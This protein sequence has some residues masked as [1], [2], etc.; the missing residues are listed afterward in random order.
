MSHGIISWDPPAVPNGP[1]SDMSYNVTV[2]LP[3]GWQNFSVNHPQTEVKVSVECKEDI[4]LVNVGVFAVNIENNISI[5]G[6]KSTK[7]AKFCKM[8]GNRLYDLI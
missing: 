5:P 4:D 2:E 6:K 7:A 1:V 3:E 8:T